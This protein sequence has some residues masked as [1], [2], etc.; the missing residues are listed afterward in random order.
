MHVNNSDVH[1]SV[2]ISREESSRFSDK[3]AI[4]VVIDE[5]EE[6]Q[7]PAPDDDPPNYSEHIEEESIESH[8][9]YLHSY[10]RFVSAMHIEKYISPI[11]IYYA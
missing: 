5:G 10:C 3:N 2:N 8:V 1:G 6:I 11:V 7:S 4:T 9:S